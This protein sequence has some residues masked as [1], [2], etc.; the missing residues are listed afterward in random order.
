MSSTITSTA[1]PGC[2]SPRFGSTPIVLHV[3]A[4]IL[5][6]ASNLGQRRYINVFNSY[7]SIQLPTAANA[8]EDEA[9]D[10]HPRVLLAK[11]AR[12]ML[13]TNVATHHGL[14]NGTLRVPLFYQFTIFVMQTST[15]SPRAHLE[16]PTIFSGGPKAKIRT[17]LDTLAH[18]HARSTCPPISPACRPPPSCASSRAPNS[19]TPPGTPTSSPAAP[20][21]PFGMIP[22]QR[23][24]D[25]ALARRLP[26]LLF[27]LAS[28]CRSSQG[29]ASVRIVCPKCTPVPRRTRS[30]PVVRNG[31]EPWFPPIQLAFAITVH[32]S[33]SLTL[34]KAILDLSEKDFV[35]G[36][37]YVGVTKMKKIDGTMFTTDFGMSRWQG[38]SSAIRRMRNLDRERRALQVVTGD[39]D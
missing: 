28:R 8:D 27:R 38:R 30:M 9:E 37:S 22:R 35:V 39:G 20:S 33:Q 12:V 19:P 32:K 6:L 16:T 2:K 24:A 31:N 15:I 18:L 34:D 4:T 26:D 36:L 23:H 10:L 14:A 13:T 29:F 11:K 5:F 21:W 3:P 7:E 25:G 17:F 1:F